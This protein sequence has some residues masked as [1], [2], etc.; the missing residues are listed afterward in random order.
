MKK[1]IF[2]SLVA[3]L[4]FSAC[5][6][7]KSSEVFD[8]RAALKASID[9]LEKTLFD[10]TSME[11]NQALAMKELGLYQEFVN[12]FPADSL[13]PEYL[14]RSSDLSR[15]LGDNVKAIEYLKQ[16]C[17]SY[18]DYKKIPESLFLQGY[19]YQ[20]FFGDTTQ[21]KSFYMQLISKYPDHAFVDDAK[22]LMQMFG[23]SD[24]DMIKSFE[25]KEEVSKKGV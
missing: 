23:K 22:A 15:A 16:V 13:S 8:E 5:S 3:V 4:C 17:K 12:K 1:V 7:D 24:E 14:F 20:E 2:G 6:S 18:P 10:Q 25:K 21:A 9:S 19:Y 11:L